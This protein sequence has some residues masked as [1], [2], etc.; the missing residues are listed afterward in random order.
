[1]KECF[2]DYDDWFSTNSIHEFKQGGGKIRMHLRMRGWI[3]M[4]LSY[5]VSFWIKHRVRM[6]RALKRRIEYF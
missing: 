2:D 3:W 5:F 4:K 6:S 1:M